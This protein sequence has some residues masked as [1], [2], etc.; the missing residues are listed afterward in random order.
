M[1]GAPLPEGRIIDGFSLPPEFRGE[2]SPNRECVYVYYLNKQ[3]LARTADYMVRRNT[4]TSGGTLYH[5]PERF[6]MHEV[7]EGDM[8]PEQKALKAEMVDH[9]DRMIEERGSAFGPPPP[10]LFDDYRGRTTAA[11]AKDMSLARSFEKDRD[12]KVGVRQ[13][14]PVFYDRVYSKSSGE[15]R[16]LWD[17]SPGQ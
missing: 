3:V 17:R 1:A 4:N 2:A 12:L 6:T 9:L 8:T 10:T 11:H 13:P 16:A 14:G 15:A 7:P 5:F